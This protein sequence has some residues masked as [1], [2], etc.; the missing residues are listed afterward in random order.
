M[1]KI[2]DSPQYPQLRASL[3]EDSPC[4]SPLFSIKVNDFGPV[5]NADITIKPC[6]VFVGP[7]QSGKSFLAKLIYAIYKANHD[8]CISSHAKMFIGKNKP[9][10]SYT[11]ESLRKLL[12]T[13]P[14]KPGKISIPE[15]TIHNIQNIASFPNWM[16]V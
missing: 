10:F 2:N 8:T 13:L 4:P 14:N 16:A 3:T 11:D 9:L 5:K 15:E 12:Q 7:N 1:N 6:T